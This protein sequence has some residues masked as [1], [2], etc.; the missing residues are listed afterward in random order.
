M[1]YLK[2]VQDLKGGTVTMVFDPADNSLY[3]RIN[4]D[5]N[6]CVT[7]DGIKRLDV[8]GYRMAVFLGEPKDWIELISY[9]S[10]ENDHVITSDYI[11]L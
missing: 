7:I 9:K 8:N 6:Y 10:L 11:E 4:D 1:D 2:R 3:F 5:K